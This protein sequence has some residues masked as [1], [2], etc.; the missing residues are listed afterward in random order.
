MLKFLNLKTHFDAV[1]IKT[2]KKPIQYFSSTAEPAFAHISV[3]Y[4]P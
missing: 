3:V 2:A 1:D 4:A